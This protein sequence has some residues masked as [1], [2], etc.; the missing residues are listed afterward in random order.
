MLVTLDDL[1]RMAGGCFVEQPQNA[2]RLVDDITWDSREV[3]AGSLYLALPG[4]RVDGHSFV[5]SAIEAGAVAALIM[6]D[7]DEAS[8]QRVRAAGGALIRVPDTA[9][10][11]RDLAGAWRGMISGRV[12]AL[13]G[14]C[15][16]TTTK[17]LVRAVLESCLSVVATAGNQ[18]N[19]LGVPRTLL[20]ADTGTQAVVVEMGMRGLGQLNDLCSYVR[21]DFGLITNVGESHI[22]LLGSRQN[23]AR[24]KAELFCAL[25]TGGLAFVNA[26]D[27]YADFVCEE[28][29]LDVREVRT[30]FFDGMPGAA[31]RRAQRIQAGR[32]DACVWAQDIELDEEGC[33]RFTLC[34]AGFGDADA[35]AAASCCDADLQEGASAHAASFDACDVQEEVCTLN[36]R[37]VHNVI[38]ACAAAAVGCACGLS[39]SQCAAALGT[40]QPEAGRQQLICAKAG[41]QLINDAYNANPDSMRASLLSFEASKV[42]GRR[43]AVLGD[44]MELGDFALEAHERIGQL[45]ASLSLDLL[46][47][48]GELSR[49]IA[50]AALDAGMPADRVLCV[51]GADEALAQLKPLLESGD[52]V[53]L[54][55]SHSVGLERVVEGLVR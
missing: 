46:L 21:P 14:S 4:Q 40:V 52:A 36:L 31:E 16:K 17:G 50:A 42:E 6:H 2:A 41:Y 45:V 1:A 27:D 5:A 51:D 8:M 35:Q 54:K 12:I 22:E 9:R 13:T 19:E 10:A 37:G 29:Q 18:N 24:A 38:N 23:I 30:V 34:A 7:L 44:M 20:K 43:I 32:R 25:P 47:C 26:A 53:L 3:K 39:L 48:V 11:L 49:R 55:A 28:A 15:G 33:P